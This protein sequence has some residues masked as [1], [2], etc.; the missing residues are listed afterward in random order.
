MT[1][2]K[3]NAKNITFPHL[4]DRLVEKGMA[5][6]KEK[7]YQEALELFSEAMKYDD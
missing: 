2:D 1:H 6:L 7:K 5:S 4:K 3:K